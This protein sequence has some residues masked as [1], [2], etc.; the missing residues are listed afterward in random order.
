M[1]ALFGVRLRI[2]QYTTFRGPGAEQKRTPR[3][4]WNLGGARNRMVAE[5]GIEPPTRGFSRHSCVTEK[6]FLIS[7]LRRLPLSLSSIEGKVIEFQ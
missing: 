4:G 1:H 3:T 6:L 7:H 2:C 5:D